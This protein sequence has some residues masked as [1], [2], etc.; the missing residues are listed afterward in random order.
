MTSMIWSV[1][2]VMSVSVGLFFKLLMKPSLPQLP[3]FMSSHAFRSDHREENGAQ[4]QQ[5]AAE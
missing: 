3:G 5:G 2:A 4:L 1:S